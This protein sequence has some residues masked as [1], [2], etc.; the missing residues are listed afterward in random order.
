MALAERIT[1]IKE[2]AKNAK[3]AGDHGV[4]EIKK[5]VGFAPMWLGNGR[6]NAPNICNAEVEFTHEGKFVVFSGGTDIG[7][8]LPSTLA[9]LAAQ[10]LGQSAGD[11]SVVTGDTLLTPDADSTSASR[12]TFAS[13]NAVI[14]AARE[15]REKILARAAGLLGEPPEGL[16][17]VRGGVKSKT[18]TAFLKLAA[19]ASDGP[20]K[21]HAKF[22]GKLA[23]P[24]DD[25]QQNPYEQYTFAT[26][27]AEVE[28]NTSNS[29]VR[30]AKLTVAYDIGQM[31]NPRGAI[32]Q[33][34]GGAVMGIGFALLEDFIPGKTYGFREYRIPKMQDIPEMVT[35]FT[36]A[37]PMADAFLAKGMGECP[38]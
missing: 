25:R 2:Q 38:R 11:V 1:I 37:P 14:A 36:D 23:W 28:V 22:E 30:V 27:M 29:Q 7:Q 5:G 34:E 16:E 18:G 33:A 12:Q 24:E 32:V 26:A 9:R 31:I 10:V 15:L 6:T 17:L 21:T 4:S 13:G 19:L 3:C 8:G 20:I 35:F